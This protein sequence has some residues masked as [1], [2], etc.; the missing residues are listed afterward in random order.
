MSKNIHN[1]NLPKFHDGMPSWD[2]LFGPGYNA[3]VKEYESIYGA[4]AYFSDLMR[5]ID[6]YITQPSGANIPAGLSLLERRPDL[7]QIVLDGYTT[8]HETTYL[9]I[10]NQVMAAKLAA[11][12]G[13]DAGQYMATNYYPLSIP[14]NQPLEKIREYLEQFNYTLAEVYQRFQAD[15]KDVARESLLL[16]P[17]SAA[18]ITNAAV[19]SDSILYGLYSD[20][21]DAELY[22]RSFFEGKTGLLSTETEEL[23]YQNLR[24][25]TFTGLNFLGTT[26][27]DC[28]RIEIPNSSALQLIG[29]QTIEF[30]FYMSATPQ[31]GGDSYKTALLYKNFNGEF[32]FELRATASSTYASGYEIVLAY[33]C[34]D[35]NANDA[36]DYINIST[37]LNI[38]TWYHVAVIRTFNGT[39]YELDCTCVDASGNNAADKTRS[40]TVSS[41]AATTSPICIG[42]SYSNG[43]S[44]QGSIAE[45]R[46]WNRALS[47][48]EIEANRWRSLKGDERALA[49]YWPMDEGEGEKI[50]DRSIHKNNG[51]LTTDLKAQWEALDNFYFGDY[52]KN[53]A[54]FKQ[55]WINMANPANYIK[56]VPPNASEQTGWKLQ[57]ETSTIAWN[58]LNRFIRLSQQIGLN[59]EDTDWLLKSLNTTQITESIISQ[60]AAA[61][62]LME[63]LKQPS[64]SISALW[65]D[66]KTYGMGPEGKSQTLFDT[67]YN[68]QGSFYNPDALNNPAPYHPIYTINP[69]YHDTPLSW[70][71]NATTQSQTDSVDGIIRSS[72]LGC[73]KINDTNLTLL[74]DYLVKNDRIT[75]SSP[76]TLL[77][78][79]THLSI[80][81]RYAMLPQWAGIPHGQFLSLLQMLNN[82]EF[83][84][85]EAVLKVYESISWFKKSGFSIYQFECL[86]GDQ[87]NIKQWAKTYKQ[88]DAEQFFD[89]LYTNGQSLLLT[90]VMLVAPG[91]SNTQAQS[92]YTILEAAGFCDV[93]GV[94]LNQVPITK[95][96]VY[97]TLAIE[98]DKIPLS[99]AAFGNLNIAEL[100]GSQSSW[101]EVIEAEYIT[102]ILQKCY[103]TQTEFVVQ[104]LGNVYKISQN[105]MLSLVRHTELQ[106]PS[107]M[108]GSVNSTFNREVDTQ[109]LPTDEAITISL[110][111]KFD[112]LDSPDDFQILYNS[113]INNS[114]FS[115]RYNKSK[116]CFSL[117]LSDTA[118]YFNDPVALNTWYFIAIEIGNMVNGEV[119]YTWSVNGK[120]TAS[121]TATSANSTNS[122]TSTTFGGDATGKNRLIGGIL[123]VKLFSGLPLSSANAIYL[124]ND[125]TVNLK[126]INEINLLASWPLNNSTTN[127]IYDWSENDH[128][129]TITQDINWQEHDEY[130]SYEINQLL[131]AHIAEGSKKADAFTYMN[132]LTINAA[133]AQWFKL[134]GEE[135]T[136][137][138]RNPLP[139]GINSM[140][141]QFQ[142]TFE[143]LVSIVNYKEL[144]TKYN[145]S[146]PILLQY[147]HNTALTSDKTDQLAT[148]MK[149]SSSQLAHLESNFT[150]GTHPLAFPTNYDNFNTVSGVYSLSRCFE[151]STKLG[152]NI[153]FLLALRKLSNISLITG[154]ADT[155]NSHWALYNN[156]ADSL[157]HAINAQQSRKTIKTD[158]AANEEQVDIK[159]R[160]CLSRLLIW[161]LGKTIA[162]IH[163]QQD[164]YEYLLIDVRMTDAV[165]MS[166][167]KAGLNSLQLYIQ[168]CMS[169]ME[170]GVTCNIPKEWWTW[171]G[172]YREWE[173]NREVFVYPENYVD[174]TLRSIESNEYANLINQ[175]QQSKGNIETLEKSLYTYLDDIAILAHLEMVDGWAEAI[176]EEGKNIQ[177]FLF[178]RTRTSPY[179]YYWRRGI[180]SSEAFAEENY[181]KAIS[182]TPWEQVSVQINARSITPIYM[183][184]KLFVFWT[185]Q[186]SKKVTLENGAYLYVTTAD[187][188]YSF[189]KTGEGWMPIQTLKKD[190]L[191]GVA[192]DSGS[193]VTYSFHG[194]QENIENYIHFP[195]WNKPNVSKIPATGNEPE[196][197]L[198][199]LGKYMNSSELTMYYSAALT[200]LS[201]AN[202]YGKQYIN[203]LETAVDRVSETSSLTSIISGFMLNSSLSVEEVGVLFNEDLNAQNY[204]YDYTN[205]KLSISQKVR[206]AQCEFFLLERSNDSS[207]IYRDNYHS[208]TNYG[209]S[210]GS[211][212]ITNSAMTAPNGWSETAPHFAGAQSVY[213]NDETWL[214]FPSSQTITFWI[215]NIADNAAPIAKTD[216]SITNGNP[217]YA[218][219]IDGDNISFICSSDSNSDEVLT[220]TFSG[221]NAISQSDNFKHI[222]FTKN[223]LPNGEVEIVCYYNGEFHDVKRYPPV[224]GYRTTTKNLCM[225]GIISPGTNTVYN[226][227]LGF[228]YGVCMWNI[229]LSGEEVKSVYTTTLSTSDSIEVEI[230]RELLNKVSKAGN[231]HT[232]NNSVNIGLLNQ[233]HEG[234][235]FLPVSFKNWL[236]QPNSIVYNSNG[237]SIQI[238]SQNTDTLNYAKLA[239]V[240]LSTSTISQL[241]ERL[242]SGGINK[243]MSLPSQMLAEYNFNNYDP[244]QN[245]IP[246]TD[247][248]LDFNG[249]FGIYF[250]ELFFYTPFYIA[251]NLQL[252]QRFALAKKWY[253]YI[254]DP[255]TSKHSDTPLSLD[256][257]NYP[258]AFWLLNNKRG[259]D[260]I[261]PDA[262]YKI[263]Y[264]GKPKL[265]EALDPTNA[266]LQRICTLLDSSSNYLSIP[267]HSDLNTAEFT[268]SIWLKFNAAN[269]ANETLSLINFHNGSQGFEF[270]LSPGATH[271]LQCNYSSGSYTQGNPTLTVDVWYQ[272]T[273]TY[274][275]TNLYIYLNGSLIDSKAVS[276]EA[277]NTSAATIIGKASANSLPIVIANLCYWNKAL[278]ATQVSALYSANDAGAI[279]YSDDLTEKRFWQFKPFRQKI[280]TTLYHNL[281]S[282]SQI[283]IYEY[284]PFNPDAIASQRPD[285]YAKGIFMRYIDNLVAYGDYLFTQN[286]WESITAATMYY[287]LASDLLGK[288]AHQNESDTQQKHATYNDIETSNTLANKSDFIIDLE[289]TP[290][291]TNYNSFS[292]KEQE[293]LEQRWSI[294]SAYFGIPEN[295]QLLVYRKTIEDRLYKIRH[296][297]TISGQTDNIPLFEPPINPADAAAAKGSES[298]VNSA[299]N[300]GSNVPYYR[301]SYLIEVAKNF[302]AQVG[303]LSNELQSALERQDGE[304][305]ELLRET[306]QNNI[307]NLTTQIKTDQLN[308]LVQNRNGLTSSLASAQTQI[309]TYSRW[310]T[311]GLSPNEILSLTLMMAGTAIEADGAIGKLIASPL[312]SVP[313]VFGMADGGMAFGDTANFIAESDM[314]LGKT[315]VGLGQISGQVAAYIRRDE[316]WNLQLQIAQNTYNQINSELA[317]NAIAQQSAQQ[318]IS[319]TQTE[320]ANS[321]AIINFLQTKFT[322]QELYEWIAGQVSSV[323][324][325]SYQLACGLAQMAQAAY[326]YEMSSTENYIN[327]GSWN[328][329]YQGLMAAD[330]LALSLNQLEQAYLKN[331]NR[332]LEIQKTISMARMNP[333]ALSQLKETGTSNFDLSEYLFDFDFPG[334]YNR[335]I[336]SVSITIP[337]IVGPYQNIKATLVQTANAVV[338]KASVLGVEYLMK[339]SPTMPSDGSLR[340]NWNANQQ[341]AI[342]TGTS[343]VGLFQLN[344]NDERYLPFE[345]TGA[346]SSWSFEMPKASNQLDFNSINDMIIEL[347]YTASDGGVTFKNEVLKIQDSNNDFV[348][349][350]YKAT[351][352][353]SLKQQFGDAWHQLLT[354]GQT[355]LGLIR[356]MYPV[357]ISN[358]VLGYQ[359]I[360]LLPVLASGIT[361]SSEVAIQ[362]NNETW[363]QTAETVTLEQPPLIDTAHPQT[364][365]ITIDVGTETD[366]YIP[367]T[368]NINPAKWLDIIIV[369]PYSG[370]LTWS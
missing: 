16:T 283:K 368:T 300:M 151:V 209:H 170:N 65:Y 119:N 342:S 266:K 34:G 109:T 289:Q 262:N 179:T 246:P 100:E 123:K 314:I 352:Y 141:Y 285:A 301:F 129:G 213:F 304:H 95:Y 32:D 356:K 292:E 327:I 240:R 338:T 218:V 334:H 296:G 191:I 351:Q 56:L 13:E 185:E 259:E 94:M 188:C 156:A 274:D 196:K 57:G 147:F 152:V 7:W 9:E 305:L 124:M 359:P 293:A 113:I 268:W 200:A 321:N 42:R 241:Q 108:V 291:L 72:L 224:K 41:I 140:R 48:S 102:P 362:L 73:L 53:P 290:S 329:Q 182:W 253:E 51:T 335:K 111:V 93:L 215:N 181:E 316:E 14:L 339:L 157:A 341:I 216:V 172:N 143:Q 202:K 276:N 206:P 130:H 90:P 286:T 27:D 46:M 349:Q 303:Q 248:E 162:G 146:E 277:V 112:S 45:I 3:H 2:T 180:I 361:L 252:N 149:W 350:K 22:Q 344:F 319:I 257:T 160:N 77:L 217:E 211:P 20:E 281:T 273:A 89:Q 24:P 288:P 263:A 195:E 155:D 294:Y 52:E 346:V 69:F 357:N 311:I 190:Q 197:I 6:T 367:N 163:T 236:S 40:C 11:D 165:K 222:A 136:L 214:H 264:K 234:I 37:A 337:A 5:I 159:L 50:I 325:Q 114:G 122:A 59:F 81:Y 208:S 205:N 336:K 83:T 365:P 153:N 127:Y 233:P 173:A 267:Y 64:E 61:K 317:A 4:P 270:V 120:V 30:W 55:L 227:S 278:T 76:N 10:A 207:T 169:N 88:P 279:L 187:I 199:T 326:Q 298:S 68:N 226:G 275:G 295:T 49:A 247:S 219:Y 320:I 204:T 132:Q 238:T 126:A 284:D 44:F 309:D 29:D 80:L 201:K 63:N 223:I 242:V 315:M 330:A 171:L 38:N 87:T 189:Q 17:E 138:S 99:K 71:F 164:L 347:K 340:M 43:Y 128:N 106:L 15:A 239:A 36:V 312:A 265:V 148:V 231:I 370:D 355:T 177:I 364:W 272:F 358:V 260:I 243:L 353:I 142:F 139:F 184:H 230:K 54:L 280:H 28:N 60:I 210:G 134:S 323:Y 194:H 121:S 175:I 125:D 212:S 92:I 96:M 70:N 203:M 1:S 369:I 313:N 360:S 307:L 150:Y 97:R 23:I 21:T 67:V 133:W 299:T 261:T 86:C 308:Q 161:D 66:M 269:S 101:K 244:T 354:T 324:Y 245:I 318:D 18:L 118:I 78:D 345:N 282:S 26:T 117:V 91:I 328:N 174:P 8:Y 39:I 168:R 154:N 366:L 249:A 271:S 25:K 144:C 251:E 297:L 333:M 75:T 322:N 103:E 220:A 58:P 331:N 31:V 107:A 110:W 166:V 256:T 363:D 137:I 250:W 229:A 192:D 221:Y 167:L 254:F 115:I 343:D 47:I 19:P 237:K 131:T 98:A 62:Q 232:I 12:F 228:I 178:G 287:V 104:Q 74:L 332:S 255:T 33:R 186:T 198:V 176:G 82:P 235:L 85:P 158:R 135:I 258:D 84:N 348:L 105:T 116:T 79:V 302:T 306:Q 183:Y 225:G 35:G 310:L 193:V 145:W